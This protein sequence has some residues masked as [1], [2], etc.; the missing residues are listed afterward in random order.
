MS[1]KLKMYSKLTLGGAI[2][3]AVSE[4]PAVLLNGLIGLCGCVAGG[5]KCIH[6]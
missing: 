6:V 2:I 1:E 4:R 5:N 3:G